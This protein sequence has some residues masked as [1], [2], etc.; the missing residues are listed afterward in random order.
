MVQTGASPCEDGEIDQISAPNKTGLINWINSSEV[1][2]AYTI[3]N[4]LDSSVLSY[5]LLQDTHCWWFDSCF[6]SVKSPRYIQMPNRTWEV[7]FQNFGGGWC[8]VLAQLYLYS[9]RPDSLPNLEGK[10]GGH[11]SNLLGKNIG[12]SWSSPKHPMILDAVRWLF[13]GLRLDGIGVFIRPFET[14]KFGQAKSLA[15]GFFH[16]LCTGLDIHVYTCHVCN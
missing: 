12:F 13:W 16:G 7:G 5:V 11:P 2:T 15:L 6:C 4:P 1:D 3:K 9:R 14:G 8:R 10:F